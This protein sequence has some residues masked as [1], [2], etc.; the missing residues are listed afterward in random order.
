VYDPTMSDAEHE[1]LKENSE[2]VEEIARLRALL[3]RAASAARDAQ[4]RADGMHD[5]WLDD[6]LSDVTA[7]G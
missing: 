5:S 7:A 4:D 1:L 2:Q 6:V 3:L